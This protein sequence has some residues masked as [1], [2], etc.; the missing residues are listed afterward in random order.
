[1]N[2]G[3]MMSSGGKSNKL[4]ETGASM[5]LHAARVSHE[6]VGIEREADG[7]RSRHRAGRATPQTP[8]PILTEDVRHFPQ[9]Q[10]ENCGLKL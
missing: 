7:A 3:G 6:A 2:E 9:S 10:L 8:M 4:G 5:P 1:M